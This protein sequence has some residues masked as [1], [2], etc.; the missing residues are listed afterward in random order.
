MF[1]QDARFACA[2]A[3]L[4]R[5]D[6]AEA[7]RAL[8]EL[9]EQTTAAPERAFLLNKRGVARINLQ[10]RGDAERDFVD[11]L[12]CIDDYAPA[13]TNLG[14]LLL[15]KGDVDAAIAHYRRAI[16]RDGDYVLA[17]QNLGVAL[18][19]AGRLDEAVRAL[20]EAQRCEQRT[21]ASASTFWRRARPR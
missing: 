18:K 12:L 1:R 8:A 7:E 3:A 17:H 9:L 19:R 21:R 13:L 5:A 4:D 15:E 6:F 16:A 11:A 20:R 10:R 14:S 2:L